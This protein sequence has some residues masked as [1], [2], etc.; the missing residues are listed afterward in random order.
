MFRVWS[1]DL[2]DE[3][4]TVPPKSEISDGEQM[5]LGALINRLCEL[6]RRQVGQCKRYLK[7]CS[8][9]MARY[10]DSHN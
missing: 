4:P 9:M 3:H 2:L 6:R 7:L 5:P 1:F 10:L 8:Y